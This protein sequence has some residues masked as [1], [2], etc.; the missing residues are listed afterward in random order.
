MKTILYN[1]ENT[2]GSSCSIDH[3]QSCKYKST[4]SL[5]WSVSG[6]GEDDFAASL[7]ATSLK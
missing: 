7:S 3:E 1:K 4:N 5:P 6:F 2:T